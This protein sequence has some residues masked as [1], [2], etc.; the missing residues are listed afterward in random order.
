MLL[1]FSWPSQSAT[2]ATSIPALMRRMAAEWRVTC[3]EILLSR[4]V[5]QEMAA[6]APCLATSRSKPSRRGRCRGGLGRADRQEAAALREPGLDE[7][8]GA[9]RQRSDPVLSAF[10]ETAHVR[11]GPKVDVGDA[12]AD[13][14]ARSKPGLAGERQHRPVT[15]PGPGGLVGSGHECRD[16]VLGEVGDEGAVEALGRDGEDALDHGRILRVT[17]RG[18]AEQRVDRRQA[19]VAGAGGVGALD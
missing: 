10:A 7:A 4:I 1:K 3:G 14:L 19:R 18:V 12:E 9:G 13:E 8:N 5:G 15:P 17:E 16:L 2:V 6:V 11:P